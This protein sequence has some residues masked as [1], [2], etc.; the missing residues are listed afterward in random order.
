VFCHMKRGKHRVGVL[1][2]QLSAVKECFDQCAPPNS[3]K[4]IGS[5]QYPLRLR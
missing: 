1:H 2:T 3:R 5:V 4:T